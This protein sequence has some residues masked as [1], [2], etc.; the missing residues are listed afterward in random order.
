MDLS[1]EYQETAERAEARAKQLGSSGDRAGAAAELLRASHAWRQLADL[2]R[3]PA[4]KSQRL[5]RAQ[6]LEE[7]ADN[8]R[9]GH[10]PASRPMLLH[11]RTTSSESDQDSEVL[12]ARIRSLVTK[13]NITWDQIAGLESVKGQIKKMFAMALAARP[14][15][16]K[17]ETKGNVLMYGPPGTGKTLL[18]AAVSK[19]LD[20]TFYS[21]TTGDLLSKYFGESS[22]LVKALYVE[23]VRTAPSVVFFD[24]F[25]SL[26]P[27]RD[28]GGA[29]GPEGRVLSQILQELDGLKT[30]AVEELVI[31]LAATN[32]PWLMDSAAQSRFTRLVYLPLPDS[33]ARREI[34]RLKTEAANIHSEAPLDELAAAS[35]GLSGR[36]ISNASNEAVRMMLDR[37]NPELSK[38]A[39]QGREEMRKHLLKFVPISKDEFAS[40]LSSVVPATRR[41]DIEEFEAWRRGK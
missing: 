13:S 17:F 37:A 38:L 23:A 5:G 14:N 15:D 27:D 40:A 22:Q 2:A 20:A 12:T 35:D 18:A 25:E 26:T 11:T 16:V 4:L 32:K 41:Q 19:Q 24:E 34:F 7:D 33:P 21:V 31:T 6:K 30:K 28:A 8:A 1:Q 3:T 39:D 9:I 29:S 10:T 36:E